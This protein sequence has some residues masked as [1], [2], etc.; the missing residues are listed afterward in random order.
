MTV[1]IASGRVGQSQRPKPV[2]ATAR[3]AKA[4][5]ANDKLACVYRKA[6]SVYVVTAF[7]SGTFTPGEWDA[8]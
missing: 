1:E 2:F 7:G 6:G 8:A 3:E 5:L 4:A